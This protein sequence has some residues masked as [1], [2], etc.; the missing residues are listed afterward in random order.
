M[1]PSRAPQFPDSSDPRT[2]LLTSAASPLGLTLARALLAHGDN[3]VLGALPSD[4]D[5]YSEDH[6]TRE[7]HTFVREE[8]EREGW[9]ER[10]IV[11]ELDGRCGPP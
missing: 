1:T 5:I 3:V 9:K 2:W 6:R 8:V 10:C 11:T 7:F 4:L